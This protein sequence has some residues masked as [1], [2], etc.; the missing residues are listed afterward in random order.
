MHRTLALTGM[1]LSRFLSPSTYLSLALLAGCGPTLLPAG[2]D[3]GAEI[4]PDAAIPE[5]PPP[6]CE[7]VQAPLARP[8]DARTVLVTPSSFFIGDDRGLWRSS[9]IGER[10]E[11]VTSLAPAPVVALIRTD[12]GAIFAVLG[13]GRV[14]T[15]RDEGEH[16]EALADL[17]PTASRDTR[18]LRTDG[19][20]I[21]GILG[22]WVSA[23]YD[24]DRTTGLWTEIVADAPVEGW[25]HAGFSLVGV[26]RGA[27]L[28]TPVDSG[29]L[30]RLERG[31][32]RWERVDDLGEANGFT[33]FA[34]R[35]DVAAVASQ[36]GIWAEIEGVYRRVLTQELVHPMIVATADGFFGLDARGVLRSNDGLDWSVEPLDG[37]SPVLV[38]ES[39]GRIATLRGEASYPSTASLSDDRGASWIEP[40]I[41]SQTFAR[42]SIHG[43]GDTRISYVA[44]YSRW[45]Y[46]GAPTW[47]R[48]AWMHVT[49]P[50]TPA[51]AVA[52]S[53]TGA[54]AC[55]Y[56]GCAHRTDEGDVGRAIAFFPEVREAATAFETS[57]GLFVSPRR[58]G[59]DCAPW[60]LFVMRDEE[61]GTWDDASAGL[62]PRIP[63]CVGRS[64]P[65][66]SEMVEL[67]GVLWATL[68]DLAHP[69]FRPVVLRSDDGGRTWTVVREGAELVALAGADAGAFGLFR[70]GMIEALDPVR[71]A[72]DPVP[73]Q[74]GASVTDLVA[75][76]GRLVAATRDANG[77]SL[78]MSDD[79]AR[80][81]ERLVTDERIGPIAD[82]DASGSVLA[83]AS[84]TS[85]LWEASGCFER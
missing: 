34:R 8:A 13:E 1:A 64:V 20:R 65:M 18:Q 52:M 54:W 47:Q 72:F 25:G 32:P 40:S 76:D 4:S 71:Q 63:S 19:E 43:D 12:D 41:A 30:F 36:A 6:S 24:L 39:G 51:T 70:P 10:F 68:A 11:R 33:T 67:D 53:E 57:H 75:L 73:V 5:A 3:A 69:A 14:M 29:G 66:V 28:A 50:G 9:R 58:S 80:S 31:A 35:G 21:V 15:S 60:G 2:P 82:L 55:S 45:S 74:P 48:G 78:W 27:L 46:E 59:Y 42:V 7:L 49:W 85:G 83:I 38:S 61:V 17:H 56:D 79:G 23:L 44:S 81:W 37:A 62:R 26:D 16:W 22:W 77:S 84:S